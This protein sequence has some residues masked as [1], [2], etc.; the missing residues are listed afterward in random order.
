[1]SKTLRKFLR[2]VYL[3][4]PTAHHNLNHLKCSRCYGGTCYSC[5]KAICSEMK[6]NKNHHDDMWYDIANMAMVEYNYPTGFIGYCCEVKHQIEAPRNS[7]SIASR[8][9]DKQE[10]K[11]DGYLHLLDIDVLLPPSIRSY[12]DINGFGKESNWQLPGLLHG[13]VNQ[14]CAEESHRYD[15]TPDVTSCNILSSGVC[16]VLIRDLFNK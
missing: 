11:Y 10:L 16:T 9:K 8:Y 5:V 14:Q 1:M 6:L 12:I 3:N 7:K 2:K 15:I 4:I 13:V